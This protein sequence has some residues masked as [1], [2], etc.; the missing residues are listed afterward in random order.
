MRNFVIEKNE[1]HI[2]G[3]PDLFGASTGDVTRME[4]NQLRDEFKAG[5]ATQ[6]LTVKR[7]DKVEAAQSAVLAVPAQVTEQQKLIDTLTSKLSALEKTVEQGSDQLGPL[8]KRLTAVEN[9]LQ[10]G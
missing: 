5:D 10:Q 7:L 6:N 2:E 8:K 4:F 1:L 3:C 9:K